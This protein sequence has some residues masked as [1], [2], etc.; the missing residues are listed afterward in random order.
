MKFLGSYPDE[1]AES[2]NKNLFLSHKCDIQFI[3][4]HMHDLSDVR[5]FSIIIKKQLYINLYIFHFYIN[6]FY[7]YFH[8]FIFYI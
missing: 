5:Y 4:D 7:R 6:F 2:L 1:K 8:F 3:S